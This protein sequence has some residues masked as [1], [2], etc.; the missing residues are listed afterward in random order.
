MNKFLFLGLLSLALA[1][2]CSP[3]TGGSS[4]GSK[5]SVNAGATGTAPV[6]PIPVG[7]VRK[8]APEAGTAPKIQ[9]GKA[10]TFK[11]ENGLTVIVVEN[12]KLPRVSF[13]VFVDNDVVM[14]KDAAGYQEI[15]GELLA[16]GTKIRSKAQINQ[17]IDFIGA[18]LNSSANGVSGS[19]LKK[20]TDKFLTILS[21]VVLNPTFPQE[22]LDKSKVK[23]QSNLAS[24]KDDANA[25]AGNVGSIIRYGKDHPYGE[26]MTEA[27]LEKITLDQIKAHYKTYFKPNISYLV[28]TGDITKEQAEKAARSHFGRW[29]KGDVPKHT[30]GVPRPPEKTQVSFVNKPGAVQSVIRV[31]YPIDLQPG[32]KDVI[33]ARVTNAILGGYFNSRVNANLREGHGWTYGA[34]TSISSDEL[35]GVFSGG[36][37]V[38]TA[39]TD[40]SLTEFLKEMRRMS[41]EKVSKE[42]LQVVKN[43]IAGQFSQSLEEP[44]TVASFALNTARYNLPSDY[45]EKYLEVLQAITPE[46]V[47]A[48]AKK[49]I[50]PDR[51]H[52]L[53]VGNRDDIADR[54]KQFSAT[55]KINFYDA[56]GSPVNS[57][58]QPLPAGMT[59]EKV[60]EDYLNAIGGA[61]KIAA[62]KDMQTDASMQMRGPAFGVKMWQKGGN[63]IAIE[64]SMNGQ[65]MNKQ[66]FDGVKGSQSAMGQTEEIEGESLTDLKEQAMVVKEA[67]Y[68]SGGYKLSLKSIEEINGSN[69]YVVEVERPDGKKSTE[70]YDMKTSLKVREVSTGQG[71]DG[72]PSVQT[73]DLTDYKAVEGVLLPHTSTVS[74]VFPVPFKITLNSVKVNAGIDD[75][76]FKM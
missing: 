48:M 72:N 35:V 70:Y 31:T 34:N 4:S 15:M 27:T 75:A 38:R 51:A 42:E 7:D 10:E 22:E 23:N 66:V 69:A 56:F 17:E 71:A 57:S 39:V 62:I 61:T 29:A 37:S 30:Y 53:V 64:M 68:K 47:Q 13:Q 16:A 19:C 65:V 67:G 2:A 41:T 8:Q 49:Y 59:A 9:I 24:Q 54:L 43:V 74:G 63:K 25:I 55:G 26:I 33:P 11:L 14:E 76:I 20:H 73:I 12:H 45:Y 5:P 3:K 21:D 1:F 32:T 40:S 28:I 44:G 6:I 50:N 46:E 52:I 36:A 18:Y 60:L 58:N